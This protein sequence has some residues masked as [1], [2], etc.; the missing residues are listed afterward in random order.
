MTIKEFLDTQK[1]DKYVITDRMRTPLKA[2]QLEWLDLSEIEV[3][4]T[5]LLTDGTVRIHSDYMPDG[6]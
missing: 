5:D 1:P 3:R 6:C 2:E 4:T